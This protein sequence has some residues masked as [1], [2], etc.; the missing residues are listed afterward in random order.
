MDYFREKLDIL[1]SSQPLY[2]KD[3]SENLVSEAP[4]VYAIFS[5]IEGKTLYVGKTKNIR[6]RVFD[7]HLAGW[8]GDK[9]VQY[10]KSK[11]IIHSK[12]DI[13]GFLVEYC[14]IR[15]V[16]ETDYKKQESLE[17]YISAILYTRNFPI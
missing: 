8:M 15:W 16:T 4:G 6:E 10:A 1:L 9:V 5:K 12:E 13:A 2:F 7:T 3:I 11:N 14:F 17:S